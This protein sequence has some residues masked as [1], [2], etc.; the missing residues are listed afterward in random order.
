MF[1]KPSFR[2]LN[3]GQFQ[4]AILDS[5]GRLK[6]LLCQLN[7]NLAEGILFNLSQQSRA[8]AATVE[9][10]L[11]KDFDVSAVYNEAISDIM[12]LRK[13]RSFSEQKLVSLSEELKEMDEKLEYLRVMPVKDREI[14]TLE[15]RLNL[16][17]EKAIGC[18]SK[19]NI[20][21]PEYE[22]LT[23]RL[24]KRWKELTSQAATDLK[25]VCEQE[26]LR[27]SYYDTLLQKVNFIFAETLAT[28]SSM[29]SQP[30]TNSQEIDTDQI[31][32]KNEFGRRC[33][34]GFPVDWF[35]KSIKEENFEEMISGLN[36]KEVSS[37]FYNMYRLIMQLH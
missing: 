1:N 7:N 29:F 8:H 28:H 6:Y 23:D 26:S 20:L 25:L 14:T 19:I 2:S 11:R 12:S 27:I 24:N 36:K 33:I 4:N 16:N 34:S 10:C 5:V 9:S 37:P 35:K 17:E 21:K 22:S 32:Q 13:E 18:R 31:K 3:W 30:K 15:S